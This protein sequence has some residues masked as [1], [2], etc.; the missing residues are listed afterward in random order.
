[1]SASDDNYFPDSKDFTE[2]LETFKSTVKPEMTC[3]QINDK[4][5]VVKMLTEGK[6]GIVG[7]VKDKQDGRMY[8]FK[9]SRYLNYLTT[10]EL[11]VANGLN[12]LKE[13]CPHFCGGFGSTKVLMDGDYKNKKLKNPFKAETKY[14][15]Y[16]DALFMEYIED[17]PKFSTFIKNKSNDVIY[18]SI[19]QVMMAIMIAQKLCKFSHYDLHSYNIMMKECD[20]DS[21]FL[22]ILDKDNVFTVPTY[23]YYPVIIDYGFS[24]IQD[25]DNNPLYSTLAHTDVGFMTN[26]FDW[27]ADP[28]L[29][30][31]TV[32]DELENHKED[33][34][35]KVFRTI[36]K[37]IFR[38]LTIDLESGWDNYGFIGASD[39]STQFLEKAKSGSKLFTEYSHFCVDVIQSLITLPL[40]PRIQKIWIKH[41]LCL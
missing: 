41:F 7:L 21:V 38:P 3:K 33:K 37:N 13:F 25:M 39:K 29:F 31:I 22:Y 20:P 26:M 15:I 19:K 34:Y 4:F 18:S 14:P 28:K 24:Y 9:L 12:K 30:L 16:I 1:M 11:Q 40:K 5:E 10:H 17:A 35:S 8:V 23:G 6:Q 27:V 32:S 36:V 2:H